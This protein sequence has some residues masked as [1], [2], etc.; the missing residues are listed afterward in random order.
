MTA[1]LAQDL[2]P[3]RLRGLLQTKRYGRSLQVLAETESTNDDARRAAAEG[4]VDGHTIL[5]DGQ[6]T[7]RGA[8]G[9]SWTS[10]AGTDLYLSI[11]ARPDLPLAALPPLTLAVGLGVAAAVDELVPATEQ[12]PALVKWPNDVWLFGKKCA[13]I[14]IET[15]S[16]GTQA[17]GHGQPAPGNPVVIG[18]GLNVNRLEFGDE[19]QATAT[20]LRA[21]TAGAA[22]LDRGKV[23]AVLLAAVEHWVD[24]F[25]AEGGDAIAAALEPRLA[26]RG[27]LIRCDD[28]EGILQGVARSGALRIATS[29]GLRDVLAGRIS[30]VAR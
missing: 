4:A 15:S 8:R 24:R 29:S 5:A 3:A 9:H 2:D 12:T 21:A 18:I 28:V 11:V 14:L 22:A 20:S 17:L 25:V 16:G 26:L 27:E 10:P 30:R 19:L 6:R 7:G 23:F 13:G 1:P